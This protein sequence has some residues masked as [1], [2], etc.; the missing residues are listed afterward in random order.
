MHVRIVTNLQAVIQ[1]VQS[2]WAD[3]RCTAG[4]RRIGVYSC[5][6]A[7]QTRDGLAYVPEIPVDDGIRPLTR[8]RPPEALA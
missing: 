7:K 5:L 2:E 1:A 3:P 6:P 8:S 4:V